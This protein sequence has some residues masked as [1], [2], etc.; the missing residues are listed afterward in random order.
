MPRHVTYIPTVQCRRN[1]ELQLNP[2]HIFRIILL[3]PCLQ[4]SAST[5]RAKADEALTTTCSLFK[6]A[7]R[8][9][10]PETQRNDTIQYPGITSQLLLPLLELR[11]AGSA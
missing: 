11:P 6:L 7:L 2:N 9:W 10:T 1:V 8:V 5:S 3:E 4:A